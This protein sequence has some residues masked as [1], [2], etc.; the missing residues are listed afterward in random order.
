M[1][2][3]QSGSPL[4]IIRLTYK[5]GIPTSR[6]LPQDKILH[7]MRHPLLRSTGVLNGLFMNQ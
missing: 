2:C 5:N 4:N 3:I 6:L 1:G 7:L